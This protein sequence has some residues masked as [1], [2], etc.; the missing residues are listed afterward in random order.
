MNIFIWGAKRSQSNNNE[1]NKLIV[2]EH[3]TKGDTVY[4]FIAEDAV[5]T[6]ETI[7]Q[8][9]AEITKADFI[10]VTYPIQW[11]SYPAAFKK[12]L[13]TLL[14]YGFAYSYNADGTVN[15]LLTGKKGKVVTTSGHPNEYYVDQLKAIHYLVDKTFLGFVG[16]KSQGALN[17]GGRSQGK[18]EGFPTEE[19]IAFVNK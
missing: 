14:S 2:S 17:I 10:Y 11:G 13:D 5:Y 7:K 16:I 19:V 1:I 8:Y 3:Q 15:Q 4:T 9:Q 18:I 12:S 6:E